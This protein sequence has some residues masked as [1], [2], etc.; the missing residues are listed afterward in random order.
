MEIC[1]NIFHALLLPP[2]LSFNIH[3]RYI[4]YHSEEEVETKVEKLTWGPQPPT[5]FFH[6]NSNLELAQKFELQIKDAL[7]AKFDNYKIRILRGSQLLGH[8]VR[9]ILAGR[10]F[11]VTRVTWQPLPNNF[12]FLTDTNFPPPF[13]ILSFSHKTKFSPNAHS[14]TILH[15]T[16]AK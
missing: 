13:L 12:A 11:S 7:R 6:L 2:G 1:G 9:K 8:V 14:G 16:G 10:N 4:F 15:E 5:K 3:S